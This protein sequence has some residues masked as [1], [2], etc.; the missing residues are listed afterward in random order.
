MYKNKRVLM[1]AIHKQKAEKQREKQIADQFEARRQ[2]GKQTRARKLE[3][4]EERLAGVCPALLPACVGVGF[5]QMIQLRVAFLGRVVFELPAMPHAA[6]RETDDITHLHLPAMTTIVCCPSSSTIIASGAA[7]PDNWSTGSCFIVT[8]WSVLSNFMTAQGLH[9][10]TAK[11]TAAAP[12][13][14]APAA[15]EEE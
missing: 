12:K 15:E 3:R 2:K 5:T 8:K 13:K 1:E 10:D 9:L 11:P 14:E 7:W 4:R 6:A